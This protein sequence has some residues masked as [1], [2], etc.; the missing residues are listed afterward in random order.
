MTP[1][2]T[3]KE[4]SDPAVSPHSKAT[5]VIGV[6]IGG[7]NLRV[8]LADS[9]GKVVGRW[10]RSLQERKDPGSVVGLICEGADQLLKDHRLTRDALI[11]LAAGAP[12]VTDVDSGMVIATSYLMGWRDVPLRDL[13]KSNF[14]LP[15]A[16][17]NDV[18]LAALGEH[19]AG[20]A[21]GES[22]FVFVAI[23]TGIG[24]GII[25]NGSLHRGHSFTAGEIGYMLVPGASEALVER[26]KPG[27]LEEIVGGNGLVRCWQARWRKDLTTLPF[28][29]TAT[30][31]L[32]HAREGNE[33]ADEVLQHAARALAYGIYN[34]SLV[35]NPSLFVLGGSVGMHPALGD[36]AWRVL[37]ERHVRMKSRLV[38]S[39]LGTDA[40][41]VG[42]VSL[43][44]ETA[45][46]KR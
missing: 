35:M 13:L 19:R 22:N 31:L 5:Y 3:R 1:A 15:V 36:A 32:D 42:A 28:E 6:D 34:I 14:E 33:L 21:R 18:N 17:E 11:A 38:R 24:A 26:G 7:T 16:I 12:G 8:G 2:T 10:S 40:Q 30:E 23:G 25:V 29:V 39:E 9:S 46:N 45:K 20:A 43:A 41:L 4:I 44:I 27:A 37:G